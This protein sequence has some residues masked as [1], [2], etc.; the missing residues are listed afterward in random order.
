MMRTRAIRAVAVALG[1]LSL[2]GCAAPPAP[3]PLPA[4][5]W[6]SPPEPGRIRY[7]GSV[8]RPEDLE[9]RK[10]WL[11]R[12]WEVIAGST[13]VQIRRPYGV[14]VDPDGRL[15]V[16]DSTGR[17]VHVFDRKEQSYRVIERIGPRRFEM[18]IGVAA[19]ADGTVFVSDSELRTV[20]VFAKNGKLLRELGRDL[21]RPTGLALSPGGDRLYVVDTL[22]HQVAIFDRGGSWLGAFGERGTGPGELNFPTNIAV[23]RSGLVYVSDTMNFEVKIFSA[24]GKPLGSFGRLGDGSGDL[25]RPKGIGVDSE[26][27]VYVVEG[28]HDVFQI[29][30]RQGRFL[31]AVGGTG[32]GAGQ[33]WLPMGLHIDREDRIYVADAYNSRVQ[34]FQYLRGGS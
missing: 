19:A 27:H 16:A 17:V 12:V 29:F 25:A 30:D 24:D 5:V 32:A 22:G 9:I 20:A 18:P 11:R 7:V 28:I 34:I 13:G 14:A 26:G 2:A 8:S 3:T 33:F 6:P 4:L 1:L 21:L 31:L 10:S 15:Y 23:D